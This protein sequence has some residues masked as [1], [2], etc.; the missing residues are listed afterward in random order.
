MGRWIR[1]TALVS[2]VAAVGALAACAVTQGAGTQGADRGEGLAEVALPA[3]TRVTTAAQASASPFT[4]AFESTRELWQERDAYE[5][6]MD[7]CTSRYG[8][9]FVPGEHYQPVYQFFDLAQP[10]GPVDLARVRTLG[11]HDPASLATGAPPDPMWDG[12]PT[13]SKIVSGKGEDVAL[14]A[15]TTLPEG[16]CTTEVTAALGGPRPHEAV[17]LAGRTFVAADK[18]PRWR[19]SVTAWAA[20]MR[21]KGHPFT[22]SV[23]AV[24]KYRP[25]AG[26]PTAAEIA[27]AVAD[28][29]CKASTRQVDIV[30]ALLDAHEAA[31]IA[32]H[33]AVFDDYARWRA[34]KTK[35][36]RAVLA[37]TPPPVRRYWLGAGGERLTTPPPPASG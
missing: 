18:D 14:P 3:L 24:E 20:C 29:E 10:Y 31:T 7:R 23:E 5:R 30:V 4:A 25:V 17:E 9:P 33:A 19:A 11:Y 15:G 22:S 21:G 8:S 1:S 37:T 32:D 12:A 28:V 13:P 36:V 34:E 16:G 27:V 26:R 35:R 2:A 6:L